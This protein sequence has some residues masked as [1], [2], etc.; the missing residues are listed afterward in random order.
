MEELYQSNKDVKDYVDA[1]CSHRN[2]DKGTAVSHKMVKEVSAF[3]HLDKKS[4][5]INERSI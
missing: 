3:Y 5:R 4:T 2:V 1:Y